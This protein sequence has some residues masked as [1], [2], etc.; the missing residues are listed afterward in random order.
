MNITD[1]I[2]NGLGQ[3]TIH[4]LD[5]R[6]IRCHEFIM[7]LIQI[8]RSDFNPFCRLSYQG[9]KIF[10]RSDGFIIVNI[11]IKMKQTFIFIIT[12]FI[13]ITKGFNHIIFSG[14][15]NPNRFTCF[16][17]KIFNNSGIC[18]FNHGNGQFFFFNLK[19][20]Y[21]GGFNHVIG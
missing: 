4:K 1:P 12:D 18:R 7:S 8:S 13:K 21:Q 20:K 14:H 11:F 10:N 9:A 6:C 2:I 3:D 17:L 16:F 19:R 5:N 15:T